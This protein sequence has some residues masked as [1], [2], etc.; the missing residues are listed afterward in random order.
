VKILNFLWLRTLCEPLEML[1]GPPIFH[2][3]HVENHSCNESCNCTYCRDLRQAWSPYLFLKK[4][5][6][7]KHMKVQGLN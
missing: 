7:T 6:T 4:Y 1:R 5:F 2:Q 3:D